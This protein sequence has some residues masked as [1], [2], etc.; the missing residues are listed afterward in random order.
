MAEQPFIKSVMR[1]TNFHVVLIVFEVH[2]PFSQSLKEKRM[3]LR[4][5]KDKLSQR[6]NL[7]VAEV[8]HQDSWQ[9]AQI[10]CS[11][12]SCDRKLLQQLRD[13]VENLVLENLD[14]EL[15]YCE[16]EWL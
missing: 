14:G 15:I 1:Q 6:F 4:R 9:R 12:L 11:S 8:G 13:Q 16:L 2:L 10:A 7:A 3:N 5:L